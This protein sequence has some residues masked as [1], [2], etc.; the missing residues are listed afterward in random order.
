MGDFWS[1]SAGTPGRM[2]FVH[3]PTLCAR[4][5]YIVERGKRGGG[6]KTDKQFGNTERASAKWGGG[7][8]LDYYYYY[9]YYYRPTVPAQCSGASAGRRATEMNA[10]G[11]ERNLMTTRLTVRWTCPG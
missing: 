1:S 10:R 8:S 6:R 5:L 2:K 4:R 9:Y 3:L 7:G 11:T